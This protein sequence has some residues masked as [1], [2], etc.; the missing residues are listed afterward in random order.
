[1]DASRLYDGDGGRRMI[2][3]GFETAGMSESV[4]IESETFEL[5][6]FLCRQTTQVNSKQH[7]YEG[8]LFLKI[9]DSLGF[10]H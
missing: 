4:E 10:G 7:P 1:V 8:D 9:F 3:A 5:H 2:D 6:R